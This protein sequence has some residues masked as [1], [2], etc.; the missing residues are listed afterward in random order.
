MQQ[1]QNVESPAFFIVDLSS[2]IFG[3]HPV[4]CDGCPSSCHCLCVLGIWKGDEEAAHSFLLRAWLRNASITSH[5]AL[6]KIL[7]HSHTYL[8]GD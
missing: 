7:S 8:N 2:S 1:L 6:T 3:F 4:V 5:D